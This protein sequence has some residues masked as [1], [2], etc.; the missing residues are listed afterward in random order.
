MEEKHRRFAQAIADGK[1]N[2]IKWLINVFK[3]EAYHFMEHCTWDDAF[4]GIPEPSNKYSI[5]EMENMGMV[6]IY[7][8]TTK[9]EKPAKLVKSCHY[10][11][12]ESRAQR[13]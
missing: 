13:L 8:D 10:C 12:A 9:P 4:E 3:K 11:Q 1:T 6:G 7:T 5:E 2:N